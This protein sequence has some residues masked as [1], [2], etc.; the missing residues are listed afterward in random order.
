MFHLNNVGDIF[1]LVKYSFKIVLQR[2]NKYHCVN[3]L[4][5]FKYNY[6]NVL[7]NN[8]GVKTVVA[9][10]FRQSKNESH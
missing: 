8:L 7:K 9:I 2:G 5:V 4:T 3:P 1:M 6:V 10:I